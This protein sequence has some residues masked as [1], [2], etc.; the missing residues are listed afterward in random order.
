MIKRCKITVFWGE[1]KHICQ[2]ICK[3]IHDFLTIAYAL[4]FQMRFPGRLFV[5]TDKT[6]RMCCLARRRRT[7]C[8]DL[9]QLGQQQQQPMGRTWPMAY[10]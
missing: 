6:I 3:Q 5:T 1:P 7:E 8:V 4:P 2:G 10:M 9:R